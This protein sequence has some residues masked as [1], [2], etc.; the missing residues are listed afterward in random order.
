[1]PSKR[2]VPL[3]VI[4]PKCPLLISMGEKGLMFYGAVEQDM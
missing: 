1:M 3:P 2:Q 4:A